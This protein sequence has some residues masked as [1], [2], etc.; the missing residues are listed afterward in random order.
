[1]EKKDIAKLSQLARI[2]I[3]SSEH[4]KLK[5]KLESVLGAIKE[6]QELEKTLDASTDTDAGEV[7]NRWRPDKAKVCPEETRRLVIDAFPGAERDA[8][9]VKKIIE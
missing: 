3:P 7:Y 5:D 6:V 9:A 1:M 2:E 8:L 4:R